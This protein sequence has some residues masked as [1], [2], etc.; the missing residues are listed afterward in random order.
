[1]RGIL[2]D[3]ETGKAWREAV[4]ERY[5]QANPWLHRI[6]TDPRRAQFFTEHAPVAGSRVLD[7]GAGWGQIALPLARTCQV[8]ALEPT[9]D[10]LEFIAAAARQEHLDGRMWFVQA[11]LLDV[12][13]GDPFDLVTCIGV[14]EWVPKSAPHLGP[15]EAQR[16]FLA[17]ARRSVAP[18]G[19]LVIG[20]ENRLGLKY[21]LGAPDDHIDCAGI[22]VYDAALAERKWRARSG[23]PLRS[24][25]H[26]RVEY[27]ALLRE[28]GFGRIRFWSAFPD[29]KLPQAIVPAGS[30]TDRFLTGSV[31][32][33]HDGIRGEPLAFQE[34]LAS[35]YRSLAA[36]GIASDFA[37][38]FFIEAEPA[39]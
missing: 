31:V 32:A 12:E 35:H 7:I 15:R 11:D 18:G 30:E 39:S 29:Y 9:P 28:A 19:R 37:P 38:S 5:A 14:L 22:A 25:T 10:R 27:E 1:M 4:G 13:F 16:A 34:E 24:L 33:E 8:C 3:I 23:Q 6:V 21:L 2:A 17:C 36:L 26:T 20:I